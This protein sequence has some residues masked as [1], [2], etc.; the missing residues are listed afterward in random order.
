LVQEVNLEPFGRRPARISTEPGAA[1]GVAD[2]QGKGATIRVA[3]HE[4]VAMCVV[5]TDDGS[6]LQFQGNS[7]SQ[8]E[9]YDHDEFTFAGYTFEYVG[10]GS[11]PT[12]PSQV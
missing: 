9:L 2:P 3:K 4:G 8:L 11:I 7:V 5:Q 6:S 1:I 10:D 12:R